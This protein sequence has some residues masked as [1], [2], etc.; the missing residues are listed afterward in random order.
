MNHSQYNYVSS[1]SRL[2]QEAANGYAHLVTAAK[3]EYRNMPIFV[4]PSECNQGSLIV[5][6]TAQNILTKC[7]LH[8]VGTPYEVFS[9]GGCLFDSV[10]VSLCGTQEFSTELRVRTT[11]EMIR[12]KSRIMSLP[13][14][15]SLMTVSPNYVA[16]VFSCASPGVTH[17]YGQYLLWQ[18]LL[19]CL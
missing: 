16:S 11:I 3:T 9:N 6:Q 19:V 15:P 12:L 14:T 13:V 1:L 5:D 2:Q 17:Q 10:S 18:M 7:R 4:R 8:D